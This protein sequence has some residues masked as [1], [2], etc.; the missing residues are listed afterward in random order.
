[1]FAPDNVEKVIGHLLRFGASRPD[2]EDLAQEALLVA[3]KKRGELDPARS[4][5]AWLYGIARNVFRNHVQ[6]RRLE[7]LPGDVSEESPGSELGDILAVRRALHAL[8]EAQQDIVIL[9]ELEGYTL[10]ETAASLSV[11]FDTAKDR[12]RRARSTLSTA[13][14]GDLDRAVGLER[15]ETRRAAKVAVA[16]V[17]A[18]TLATLSRS[19]PAVAAPWIG[20][21]KILA[22]LAAGAAIAL[23]TER[24]IRPPTVK[25][26][27]TIARAEPIAIDAAALAL[28]DAVVA[29][30]AAVVH[31]PQRSQ[32]P[33][34]EAELIEHARTAFRRRDLEVTVA[35]LTEHARLYPRGQLAEERDLLELEVARAR[36]RTGEVKDGI[37]RFRTAYPQSAHAAAIDALDSSTR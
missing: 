22:L 3:W 33:A 29:I 25:P 16:S 7:P 32:Q 26:P 6:K 18:A 27:P 5:D 24:L 15:T 19:T 20:A 31:S 30:D 9:H 13:L 23:G 14:G 36:G 17:L 10:K 37:D 11:P 8:P 12:L 35:A 21:T 28:P 4:L 34:T 1:M 2:A